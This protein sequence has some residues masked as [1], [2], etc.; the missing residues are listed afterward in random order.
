MLQHMASNKFWIRQFFFSRFFEP[1]FVS[2]P[3]FLTIFLVQFFLELLS[4][5]LTKLKKC[6]WKT[7]CNNIPHENTNWF[8]I[9]RAEHWTG[10]HW[11]STFGFSFL[12]VELLYT[13]PFLPVYPFV[14]LSL[15]T[16]KLFSENGH[17]YPNANW[18]WWS[19]HLHHD[20]LTREDSTQDT[21]VSLCQGWWMCL[22]I[23][24]HTGSIGQL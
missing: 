19:W 21:D 17:L 3:I 12:E 13:W 8:I 7:K 23:I 5:S 18:P 15:L 16:S 10:P 24:G 14:R 2:P 22:T 20:N 11:K 6:Y 9:L 1:A 4:G